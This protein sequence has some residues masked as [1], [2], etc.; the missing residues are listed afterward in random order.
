M[1][2]SPNGKYDSGGHLQETVELE[3][4]VPIDVPVVVDVDRL[5][6]IQ[7]LHAPKSGVEERI[8][9]PPSR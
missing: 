5:E 1:K 8:S 4:L 9:A 3:Q 7:H 6:H 2:M